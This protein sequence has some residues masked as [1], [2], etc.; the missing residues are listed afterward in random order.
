MTWPVSAAESAGESEV[1][2]RDRRERESGFTLIEIMV[3]VIIIAVVASIVAPAVWNRVDVAKRH[4]AKGQI[5]AFGSALGSY[6]LDTGDYPSSSQGLQALRS[7]PGV[8]GW[9]GPYLSQD[10]PKDP[11]NKEYVYTYP[12]GN[13]QDSYEIICYGKDGQAGGEGVNADVVSWK[14]GG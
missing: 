2:V 6:R 10:V 9:N 5:A 13:A 7:T 8:E 14:L 1:I 4:A 3:V 11:W 12:S